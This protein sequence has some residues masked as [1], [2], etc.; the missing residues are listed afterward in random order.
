MISVLFLFRR[1]RARWLQE[2]QAGEGS[3]EF[4]YGM[5]YLDESRFDVAF[6]EGDDSSR[7]WRWRVCFPL[8]WWI[9]RRVGIGFGLHISWV[10][11][12][13]IQQADVLISTV[14]TVGL[15]LAM[16]KYL[17][18]LKTPLIYI[19]QG[20]AYRMEALSPRKPLN[21]FLRT[22][23]ARFLQSVDRVVVLGDGAA[24]PL[25]DLFALS[26][27]R[28][29]VLPF[30]MDGE[31][32][33]PAV[34]PGKGSY[35]LSIGSDL[36][37]D[38]PTLLRAMNEDE[39]ELRIVT[40]QKLPEELLSEAVH[41]GSNYTSLELRELYRKAC[42]VVIPLKDVD[43]PSGQSATL[44]AMA[45]GKAVILTRTQGLWEPDQMRHLENC[46]LVEPGDVSGLRQAIRYLSD[47]PGEVMRIGQNARRTVEERYSTRR[48]AAG[49][50]RQ[51]K[52][53]MGK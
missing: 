16:L 42:F 38:Y 2:W 23:Y 26:P 47:H 24:Q 9:A 46:Y 52:Q 48:F 33:K 32:W 43:Q 49:L 44:Q 51:I 34:Q 45:C 17:G 40:R 13:R 18:V 37:R 31:F 27:D 12:H 8:E 50:E 29:S 39:Q 6:V 30:G 11:W 35:I 15:P 14:D 7:N 22:S 36:A 10:N 21:R 20:L 5:P 25:I 4:L 3:S 1:N 28:V 53:V 19:S 41:I